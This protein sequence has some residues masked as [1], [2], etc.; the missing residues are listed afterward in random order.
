[1]PYFPN[2]INP[3][4]ENCN[5]IDFTLHRTDGASNDALIAE[6]GES[7]L[8]SLYITVSILQTSGI[9]ILSNAITIDA[10]HNS[11]ARFPPPKCY[12]ETREVIL[13]HIIA[14]VNEQVDGKKILWLYGPAGAGKSAIAQTLSERFA[15]CQAL[16]ASFFFTRGKDQRGTVNR[17][18]AT[19]AYQL[20]NSVLEMRDDIGRA[21]SR[22]PSVLGLS[23]DIQVQRLIVEP[24]LSFLSRPTTTTHHRR[25]LVIIDGLDE[26]DGDDNQ[27]RLIS[28]IANLFFDHNLPLTFIIAS[29]PEP[30]IAN[31]FQGNPRISAITQEF[32]LD[33]SE[34]DIR[35]FLFSSFEEMRNNHPALDPLEEGWPSEKDLD[36][37]VH[38][39]SGYFIYASTVIK[40]IGDKDLR[41]HETLELVLSCASSPFSALDNLYHQIL[42]TTP[43][44]RQPIL[45]SVLE[46][47]VAAW[48]SG[49]WD[50]TRFWQLEELL[51]LPRGDVRLLLRRMRSIFANI[52][53]EDHGI[54]S[55]HAS[56]LDFLNDAQRSRIFYVNVDLGYAK[57]AE[58][59]VR[60]AKTGLI[61]IEVHHAWIFYALYG[62]RE[63][64][65]V[66]FM[67]AL[68][69]VNISTWMKCLDIGDMVEFPRSEILE[70]WIISLEVNTP[71]QHY[72]SC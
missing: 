1:M 51:D 9:A 14:W 24:F 18:V 43:K 21:V 71:F 48:D 62:H 10:A 38:R 7:L 22:D 5:L 2:A 65:Y 56:L 70:R 46:I 69:A 58:G 32:E 49:S 28:L 4:L 19:I 33:P 39:S 20:A 52:D 63:L 72:M 60:R 54:E 12:P 55:L 29:R 59:F 61:I 68:H 50:I 57:I 8:I 11:Q 45:L 66:A 67:E 26:C 3:R 17:V 41:P 35:T 64:D 13:S 31:F 42:L 6:Q 23:L 53:S 16:A 36:N 15:L 27:P 25:Y 40:F 47:L 30:H 37:L 34:E 44:S